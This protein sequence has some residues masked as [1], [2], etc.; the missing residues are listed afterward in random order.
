AGGQRH[1]PG[2]AGA[3]A[4]APARG[5][6]DAL[7]IAEKA[8]RR[9][10]CARQLDHLAEAAAMPAGAARIGTKLAPPEDDRRHRLRCL[11]RDGAHAAGEGGDVEPVLARPRAGA[12]AM[13]DDGAEGF[14]RSGVGPLLDL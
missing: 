7:E 1:P 10:A 13:E 3:A 6:A 5:I 14:E 11:D 9:A 12:A 2:L 4:V 8:D